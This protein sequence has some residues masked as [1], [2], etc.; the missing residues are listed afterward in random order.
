MLIIKD[1]Q[2]LHKLL[3]ENERIVQDILPLLIDKL[4]KASCNGNCFSHFP[5]GD[6]VFTPGCDGYT[7]N[8][9]TELEFVPSGTTFWE[10]GTNANTIEKI[11]SDYIKRKNDKNIKYKNRKNFVIVSAS[12]LNT[13]KKQELEEKYNKQKVFKSVHIYDSND[14]V[15]WINKHIEVALWL[16]KQCGV[17]I[18]EYG[19]RPLNDEWTIIRESTSPI[20]SDNIY[21]CGNESK[22]KQF[23]NDIKTSMSSTFSF[24]SKYY[25]RKHAYYFILSSLILSND[26]SL[27]ERTLIVDN[28][29]TFSRIDS[30]C[31]NKIIILNFADSGLRLNR[32]SKNS[33]VFFD[34]PLFSTNMLE[35]SDRDSFCKCLQESGI[36]NDD[37]NKYSYYS[38]YNPVALRRL[39]SNTPSEKVPG[40]A[41]TSEK[42]KLIPLMLL[43]EI[44]MNESSAEF[45]LGSLI[46]GNIDD[47]IYSLNY[48]SEI[49]DPAVFV[50]NG[51]YRLGCRSEC[52]NYV[53]I[54]IFLSVLKK[55]EHLLKELLFKNG[56][57]KNF[58]IISNLVQGFILISEKGDTNQYHFDNLVL[59]ILD[60]INSDLEKAKTIAPY[61]SLLSE[62]SPNAFIHF[63]NNQIR[64]NSAFLTKFCSEPKGGYIESSQYVW[65][66]TNAM[67]ISFLNK[68]LVVD[69]L[70][71]L[72]ELYF[73]IDSSKCVKD[74]LCEIM[75][76]LASMCGITSIPF[77]KKIDLFFKYISDKDG[78]K[79]EP[80]VYS[81]YKGGKD[82]I[83]SSGRNTYRTYNTERF[84]CY[85][86]DIFEVNKIAFSWLVSHSDKKESYIIEL[87]NNIHRNPFEQMKEEFKQA[88]LKIC[89]LNKEE[90][91]K[92]R[93]K[94]IETIE[95]IRRFKDW[96]YLTPYIPI[97]EELKL[98]LEPKD[99]FSK[100]KYIILNDYFPLD[101]PPNF[102]DDDHIEKERK[103]R[104]IK[105]KEVVSKLFEFYGQGLILKTIKEC[106][107][108]ANFIWEEYYIHSDD[109]DRD[110]TN[111]VKENCEIGLKHYLWLIDISRI[112]TILSKYKTTD[113]LYKCLPFKKEIIKLING[114][115]KEHI[116]WE[117]S[118][119]YGDRDIDFSL[120]FD[121]FL[122]FAPAKIIAELA[123]NRQ[124]EYQDGIKFLQK[125]SNL[126]NNDFSNKFKS[127]EIYGIQEI[128]QKMDSRYYSDELASS[129]FALLPIILGSLHD[130]PLG[131]KKYFWNN[132]DKFAN[133]LLS[134]GKNNEKLD[135]NSIEYKIYLDTIFN[136]R[137][138]CFVPREYL[139]QH[140]E[141]FK[142]WSFDLVS[143]CNYIK[144]ERGSY[145]I[146]RAII[147]ICSACPK[148]PDQSVW[149][150]LEVA[151]VLECL[152]SVMN[153]N[154]KEVSSDF[155]IS[156]SNRRGLRTITNGSPE[157]TIRD[158]YLNYAEHYR[159]THNV[160]YNALNS[161]ASDYDREGKTD[162]TH[163]DL[164]MF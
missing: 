77:I 107:E 104:D 11:S 20:L 46:E 92:V 90:K 112:K 40:W 143:K 69:A 7:N 158:E 133:L 49:D 97:L 10:A 122:E 163:Y 53:Q 130:Y 115:P 73:Q 123:Y 62:L 146:C 32:D 126:V 98:L 125:I 117:N 78:K 9:P 64:N 138:S 5:Y 88:S 105:R 26:Q 51:F 120:V 87:F 151:D 22:S 82:V 57:D 147:S 153:K 1:G 155:A 118:F 17:K 38:G 30:L 61:F 43:G 39:L 36:S 65:Y 150:I 35:I 47:Y 93:L 124:I 139:T 114:N 108:T 67:R 44:N 50:Y 80:L 103:L 34:N 19:V 60:E 75:S 85:T 100:Y 63:L 23:I 136:I 102:E 31:E 54:D 132:P 4:I 89:D 33:V 95:N 74:E 86:S 156:V 37:A 29:E 41:R 79:S 101:N 15:S 109:I 72:L 142:K 145:L 129:E 45:L 160:V 71:C 116:F 68:N 8:I 157:F 81:L 149:P 137:D 134:I 28:I 121:K 110:I 140:P 96:N 164:G 6:A 94:T 25:G 154:S 18:D 131:I 148:L 21:L 159:Y 162:K 83:M 3:K 14:L 12:L 127:D 27:I 24:S 76:P 84:Q 91:E 2:R 161:I 106:K 55:A 42:Y 99:L 141:T 128:I 144:N 66:I 135:K 13:T 119:Y 56:S 48:L 70:V 59:N 113:I 58:R 111:F 152:P 52:F 16:L